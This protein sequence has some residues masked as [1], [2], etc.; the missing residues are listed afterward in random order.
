MNGDVVQDFVHR[1]GLNDL[2]LESTVRSNESLTLEAT[3]LLYVNMRFGRGF[4]TGFPS[5]FRLHHEFVDILGSIGNRK[6]A[7]S[8]SMM[9][10]TLQRSQGD[11]RW[12]E[13]RLGHGFAQ[14]KSEP[15]D[16]ITSFDDLIDVAVA[17]Y[18]AVQNVLGEG[19]ALHRAATLENLI[20]A[21][22]Q[23]HDLGSGLVLAS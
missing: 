1:I 18:Q 20:F 14:R 8:D 19:P 23:L 4:V 15:S 5:A 21:L 10:E 12:I 9:E 17:Q 13:H 22:E 7:F 2:H 16:A 6:L 11:I 3:A